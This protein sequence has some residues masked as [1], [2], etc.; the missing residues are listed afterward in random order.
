MN[1][2]CHLPCG[3]AL[4]VLHVI[5][6]PRKAFKQDTKDLVTGEVHSLA[7]RPAKSSGH[8]LEEDLGE[9]RRVAELPPMPLGC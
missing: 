9:W 2:Y 5:Y 8:E 1:Y 6:S 7:S 4:Q 3:V